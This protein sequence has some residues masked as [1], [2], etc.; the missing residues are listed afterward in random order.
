MWALESDPVLGS[1]NSSV[2]LC[3]LKN[4]SESYVWTV[5]VLLKGVDECMCAKHLTHG[6]Y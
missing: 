6:K 4:F 2:A 3:K 5:L 1:A